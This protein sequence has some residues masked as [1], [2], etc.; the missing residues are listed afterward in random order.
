MCIIECVN[1]A[2]IQDIC[3]LYINIILLYCKDLEAVGHFVPDF[4]F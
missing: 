4:G 2:C 3:F 1:A